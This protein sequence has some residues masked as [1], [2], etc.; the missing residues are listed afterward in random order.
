[1][2]TLFIS[3]LHLS[4]STP[5]LTTE[6]FAFL[7]QHAYDADALYILGDL[8]DFWIGDD[9]PTQFAS[10]IKNHLK[11]L[12]TSGVTCYFIHGNRDFLLKNRFS[13]ETGVILLAEETVIN[14]YGQSVLL[15]H[16][17]T[18]C[19][20]DVRYLAFRA[21]VHTPWIQFLYK[22]LPFQVK[23]K[24]VNKIQGSAKQD[25]NDK[26]DVIMDVTQSTVEKT[27][28]KHKVD[29]LIHGHTHRPN[30]HTFNL[31]SKLKHRIVLGDW[32]NYSYALKVNNRFEVDILKHYI[33]QN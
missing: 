26:D 22:F 24:I 18:L 20:D 7:E 8:F 6:F 13:K 15:M 32:R 31:D 16:G 11:K 2:H 10:E 28:Q 9:D 29:F 21:K 4:P 17:D 33:N 12:T 23:N 3:D 1:M 25:K 5:Q 14:L 30:H 27:M 19:T